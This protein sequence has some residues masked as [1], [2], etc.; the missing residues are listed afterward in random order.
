MEHIHS[1][2][3]F[4]EAI[5]RVESKAKTFKAERGDKGFLTELRDKIIKLD[6]D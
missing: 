5:K 1:S 2:Y 3:D 4:E 6:A